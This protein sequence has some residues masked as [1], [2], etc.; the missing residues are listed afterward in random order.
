[1]SGDDISIMMILADLLYEEGILKAELFQH[2]NEFLD[3]KMSEN[4]LLSAC[5]RPDI[6]TA[7]DV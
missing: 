7:E 4:S 1:M 2:L 6:Q 5:G 3:G